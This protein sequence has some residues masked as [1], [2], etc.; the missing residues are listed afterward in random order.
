MKLAHDSTVSFLEVKREETKSRIHNPY[1]TKISE[2]V[3]Q[4]IDESATVV[5]W[6][7]T[8]MSNWFRDRLVVDLE[9]EK[10]LLRSVLIK[11]NIL[12]PKELAQ[13]IFKEKVL[14]REKVDSIVNSFNNPT[15][16]NI[17]VAYADFLYYLSGART[18]GSEGVLP[19]ENLIDFSI[20]DL[21]GK[22]TNLSEHEIFFKIFIDTVKAKTSTIF[23]SDFLDAISMKDALELRN[24]AISRDFTSKYNNIQKKTK[25]GLE[26]RDPERLVLLMNELEELEVELHENYS[27]ELDKELPTRIKENK[28]RNTGD[29]VNSVG[30]I[31][32]PFYGLPSAASNFL[33]SGMKVFNMEESATKLEGKIKQGL[34]ACEYLLEDAKLLDKQILLD[35]VD[36]MKDKFK[37]K[38]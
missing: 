17:I 13:I 27:K 15:L 7:V 10:S 1:H 26:I 6:E 30:Q 16:R 23:P 9:D 31:L 18:T 4:L 11:S 38:M 2:D 35:F 36:K 25:G 21:I 33:I 8:Q 29:V 28:K 24:I 14:R 20:G 12:V 19:Q 3:A 5:R 34:Q 37:E 32:I 22:R